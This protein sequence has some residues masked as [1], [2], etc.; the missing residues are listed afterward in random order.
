MLNTKNSR[1][2]FIQTPKGCRLLF[3]RF[4]FEGVKAQ[5]R[6]MGYYMNLQSAIT[7]NWPLLAF[8]MEKGEIKSLGKRIGISEL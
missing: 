2:A 3:E 4:E 6:I 5:N 8:V 1:L 7:N